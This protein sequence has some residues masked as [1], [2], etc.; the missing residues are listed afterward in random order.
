MSECL[1]FL[2]NYDI[3]TITESSSQTFLYLLDELMVFGDH[4]PTPDYHCVHTQG[5]CELYSRG[6]YE[7]MCE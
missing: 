5:R 1:P 2:L 7:V 3:F 6:L 4:P